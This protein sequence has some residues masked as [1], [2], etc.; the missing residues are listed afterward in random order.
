MIIKLGFVSLETDSCIYIRDDI[1]VEIYI[2]DI[3]IVA[4]IM[5]QC[6]VVYEELKSY[7]KIESKESIKSFLGINIT[8]NCS[9]YLIILDQEIYIDRF[10]IE[11]EFINVHIAIISL[12]KSLS[13][14]AIISNEKICNLEYYQ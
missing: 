13:L 5:E 2:D 8:R 7:I 1:I 14:L 11:Y 10:I 12:E 4:P 6:Q 3:N 9:Q